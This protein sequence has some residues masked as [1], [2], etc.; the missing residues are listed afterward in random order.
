MV[1]DNQVG[2]KLNGTHKLLVYAHDAKLL[3][4][5]IDTIKRNIE[6]LT[7]DSKEVGL[8]VNTE[9]TTICCCLATRTQVKIMT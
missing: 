5:N 1:Q 2:L 7:G 9:K 8:E 6:N 3:G 4:E